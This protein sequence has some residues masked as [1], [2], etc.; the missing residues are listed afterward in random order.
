MGEVFARKTGWIRVD[1]EKRAEREKGKRE[2]GD[3][4]QIFE[5]TR[6]RQDSNLRRLSLIDF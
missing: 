3:P 6:G 1:R 2:D 5:V 4:R